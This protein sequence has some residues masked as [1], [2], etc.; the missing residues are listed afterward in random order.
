MAGRTRIASQI[1]TLTQFLYLFG[2][3]VKGFESVELASR[4]EPAS[5]AAIQQNERNKLRVKE[6][7]RNVR[8]GLDKLE[9]DFRFQPAL[10]R[11]Y[12]RLAGVASAGERAENQA[13]ANHFDEAGRLLL[14]VVDQLA[15]TLAAMR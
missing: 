3:V 15:D 14:K 9:T 2:G 10:A 7:I 6:S 8:D 1:K 11:Y 4:T 5:P 12:Q 13:M